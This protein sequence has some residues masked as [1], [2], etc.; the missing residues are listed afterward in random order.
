MADAPVRR[1][2]KRPRPQSSCAICHRRKVKC[3]KTLPCLQCQKHGCPDECR[4]DGLQPSRT[5][6][7]IT[8]ANAAEQAVTGHDA[9]TT[10]TSDAELRSH[11]DSADASRQYIHGIIQA[12]KLQ[13][14]KESKYA[15]HT[16][17][18]NSGTPRGRTYSTGVLP[19]FDPVM[20]Y[21]GRQALSHHDIE[22]NET[23]TRRKSRMADLIQGTAESLYADL[24]PITTCLELIAQYYETWHTVLALIDRSAFDKSFDDML[25][26]PQKKTS[27][28]WEVT[29]ALVLAL[30]NATFASHEARISA[31]RVERWLDMASGLLALMSWCGENSLDLIKASALL[32]LAE[33]VL[34]VDATAAYIRSGTTV[35][36]AM[37]LGLHMRKRDQNPA[38]AEVPVEESLWNA[39]VEIDQYACLAAGLEPAVPESAVSDAIAYSN[40]RDLGS[41]Y[42]LDEHCLRRLLTRSLYVRHKILA[43]LNG[44]KHLMIE[45][46]VELSTALS[47]AFAPI[48]TNQDVPPNFKTFQ[49]DYIFFI[50]RRYMSAL[51]RVFATQDGEPAYYICRSM[52]ARLARKHLRETCK[53]WRT[54]SDPSPFTAL[55]GAKGLMFRCETEH[56]VVMLCYELY[57]KAD[58]I[59]RV[60]L[61]V[62]GGREG[63]TETLRGFIQMAKAKVKEK[64][65]P[66]RCFM[67]SAMVDA[68]NQ[69]AAECEVTSVE[70]SRAMAVVG[71]EVKRLIEGS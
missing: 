2:H 1:P 45:Q 39:I 28:C 12:D 11:L 17:D 52:A 32:S 8:P 23:V 56:A 67:I 63:L 26:E 36:G 71:S 24:P 13:V 70:Y 31:E 68:H 25:A 40:G 47:K 69:F 41:D 53:A 6:V 64:Q 57:R 48:S 27:A 20:I 51:H 62:E 22:P 55:L 18:S 43:V 7:T 58:Q 15:P 34:S 30:A 33:Q 38:C 5:S 35:R 61:S 4:Y 54:D 66:Q 29:C 42:D 65:F 46:T 59:Q 14:W 49:Y 9:A 21:I 37:A 60:L 50:Y 16:W 10:N 19:V 3:S 44:Q